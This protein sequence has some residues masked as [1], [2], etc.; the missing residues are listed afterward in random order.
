[1]LGLW[2]MLCAWDQVYH[3]RYQMHLATFGSCQGHVGAMLGHVARN[4]AQERRVHL[5]LVSRPKRTCDFFGLMLGPWDQVHQMHLPTLGSCQGH[6]ELR[7]SLKPR[8]SLWD[9]VYQCI[10]YTCHLWGHVR[11]M[12]SLGWA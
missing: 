2:S 1:M 9:K 7:L 11:G 10:R 3:I 4:V 6:V 12:L 8:L 5:G